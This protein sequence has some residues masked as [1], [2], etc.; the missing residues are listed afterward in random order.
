MVLVSF[1]AGLSRFNS[2]KLTGA[3]DK[4]IQGCILHEDYELNRIVNNKIVTT[5]LYYEF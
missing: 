3:S 4:L 2:K 1:K 5:E